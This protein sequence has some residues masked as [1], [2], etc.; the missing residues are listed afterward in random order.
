MRRAIPETRP[1]A[2]NY[3]VLGGQ[4]DAIGA[5]KGVGRGAD[6]FPNIPDVSLGE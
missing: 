4:V 5:Q 3:L 6:R 1:M 2:Q